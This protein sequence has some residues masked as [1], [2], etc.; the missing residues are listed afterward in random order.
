MSTAVIPNLRSE[1]WEALCLE[2]LLSSSVDD[3]FGLHGPE[4]RLSPVEAS[5]GPGKSTRLAGMY[6]LL[7]RILVGRSIGLAPSL[8]DVGKLIPA[9]FPL[10]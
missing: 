4:A 6:V 9:R 1:A 7:P 2:A 5:I 10:E 3:D 8:V